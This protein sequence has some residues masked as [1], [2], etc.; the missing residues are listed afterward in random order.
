MGLLA[1]L[2]S[3][4]RIVG[5]PTEDSDVN[6]HKRLGNNIRLIVFPVVNVDAYQLNLDYGHGC[7]RTNLNDS[8]F[9][10]WTKFLRN[11]FLWGTAAGNGDDEDGDVGPPQVLPCPYITYRGVDLNRNHPRDWFE[12]WDLFRYRQADSWY[13]WSEPEARAIRRVVVTERPTAALSFHSR[14]ASDRP[15]LLIHPYT[16]TRPQSRMKVVNQQ[17]YQFYGQALNKKQTTNPN[18]DP[19]SDNSDNN[20]QDSFYL[21]GP[22]WQTIGYTATG[23]TIDWMHSVGVLSFVVE[24]TPPCSDRTTNRWCDNATATWLSMQNYGETSQRLAQLLVDGHGGL[25]PEWEAIPV[26]IQVTIWLVLVGAGLQL[27]VFIT[28]CCC[29][30]SCRCSSNSGCCCW[31]HKGIGPYCRRGLVLLQGKMKVE[32]EQLHQ[33]LTAATAKSLSF[34][35]NS[36]NKNIDDDNQTKSSSGLGG[37][38]KKRRPVAAARGKLSNSTNTDEESFRIETG[39]H[40]GTAIISFV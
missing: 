29:C 15:P 4:Q 1:L 25:S 10:S 37:G 14:A 18:H 30:R 5:S 6:N 19:P 16:S 26:W 21:V 39:H 38:R 9:Y 20:H 24:V 32:E 28:C 27:F 40:T 8:R 36:N 12:S 35:D 17:Q 34:D 13:P 23:S 3:V 22:A 33:P 31:C 2:D 7:R 11:T